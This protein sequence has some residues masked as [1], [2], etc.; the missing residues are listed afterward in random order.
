V[1]IVDLDLQFGDVAS[2]LGLGPQSTVADASRLGSL[3][4]STALKVFL[5]P[6]PSGLYALVGPHFPAEAEEVSASIA[7]HIIDILAAEFAYV[8]VDTGAGLDEF[9]LAAIERADD[10]VLV[11][12]T[13][14]PSVRGMR[15]ALDAIDLLGMTKARRHLVLNRSDDKVGLAAAD[16]EATIGVPVE[17]SVPTSR[18]IQISVNQGAPIVG[19]EPRSPAGRALAGLARGFVEAAPAATPAEKGRRFS[20]KDGK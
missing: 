3:L 16:V 18:S 11:C 2:A 15:K 14:V 12:V 20:R 10:L 9:A 4:D 19:S 5:E 13:D 17:A 7:G 8:I 6:H 1:A